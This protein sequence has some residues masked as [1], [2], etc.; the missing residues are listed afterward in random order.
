MKTQTDYKEVFHHAANKNIATQRKGAYIEDK[1]PQAMM[2]CKLQSELLFQRNN[3]GLP[4]NLKS[5]I[6]QMSGYSLDNVSV[7]YNSSKPAQL[8]AHAY[9]NGSDIHVASGQEKYLPH[10]AW[11]V[12]QQKQGRVRPTFQMNNQVQIN[13]DPSLEHEADVMGAKALQ[14]KSE[15]NNIIHNNNERLHIR[16]VSSSISQCNGLNFTVGRNVMTAALLD[17]SAI[18]NSISF[19][20]KK[21]NEHSLKKLDLNDLY[22]MLLELLKRINDD[23]KSLQG[24]GKHK[25][26]IKE[27]TKYKKNVLIEKNIIDRYLNSNPNPLVPRERKFFNEFFKKRAKRRRDKL[28]KRY[29]RPIVPQN[30]TEAKNSIRSFL[31]NFSQSV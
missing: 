4:N 27:L 14:M 12:V 22:N 1:R 2:Q 18:F 11:H 6:E 8:Q 26:K 17:P 5:G 9:T 31:I 20:K 3:T 16:N 23:I 29:F 7:H 25:E 15:T 19:W 21:I 13:D 24:G 30:E 10:E 28:E